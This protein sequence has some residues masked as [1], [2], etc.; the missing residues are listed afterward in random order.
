MIYLILKKL[1]IKKIIIY[2]YLSEN[3]LEEDIKTM[4]KKKIIKKLAIS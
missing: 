1:N 3:I 4:I 2:I